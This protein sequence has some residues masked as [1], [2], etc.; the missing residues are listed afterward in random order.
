MRP[1]VDGRISDDEDA[2]LGGDFASAPAV[3][4]EDQVLGSWFG[5]E[6]TFFDVAEIYNSRYIAAKNAVTCL[7][8]IRPLPYL[9]TAGGS[10]GKGRQKRL[11]FRP[12]TCV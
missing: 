4:G 11:G 9:F 10:R 5:V 7:G 1:V 2:W 12:A 8:K 3:G 6:A